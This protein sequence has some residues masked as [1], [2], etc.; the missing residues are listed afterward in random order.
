VLLGRIT[1]EKEQGWQQADHIALATSTGKRQP[2]TCLHKIA[3]WLLL[4]CK[5]R[6]GWCSAPGEDVSPSSTTPVD[7]RFP[8]PWTT[9]TDS[10]SGVAVRR[11][12]HV[13]GN[14]FPKSMRGR[15]TLD[16][17][18]GEAAALRKRSVFR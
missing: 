7:Q 13:C 17:I 9:S 15:S 14:P 16:S 1:Q 5:D 3:R 18:K 12:G 11:L 6:G 2:L 4:S 8:T 10:S